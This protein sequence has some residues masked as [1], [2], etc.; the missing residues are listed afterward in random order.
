VAVEVAASTLTMPF[1]HCTQAS[2]ALGVYQP[3]LQA[4]Q[5]ALPPGDSSMKPHTVGAGLLPPLAAGVCLARAAGEHSRQ[6]ASAAIR[7]RC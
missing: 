3:S 4:L 7:I 1:L 6:Q 2:P 5:G